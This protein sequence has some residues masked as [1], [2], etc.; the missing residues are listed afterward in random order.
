MSLF[1]LLCIASKTDKVS[2]VLI[3]GDSISIG[4]TP[5]VQK[6]LSPGINVEHNEGNGGSTLRGIE[7]IDK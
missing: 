4:Y 2:N 7:N 6:T 3:I 1:C 5:F